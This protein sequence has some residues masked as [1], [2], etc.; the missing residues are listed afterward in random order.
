MTKEKF[1]KYTGPFRG[2]EKWTRGLHILNRI[3]TAMGYVSYPFLLIYLIWTKDVRFFQALLVPG[4][5]FMAVTFFRAKLNAPRPYEVYE[6]APLIPKETRGHSFPS[7]HVFSIFIIAMTFLML[8]PWTWFGIVLLAAGVFLAVVRVLTGV[9]FPRDVIAGALFAVVVALVFYSIDFGA[10][11]HSKSV[12]N[13]EYV[14]EAGKG[15]E[16]STKE[17][18]TI[19]EPATEEVKVEEPVVEEPTVPTAP[20]EPVAVDVPKP[21]E[22]VEVVVSPKAEKL[23]SYK[24]K[25]GFGFGPEFGI[26]NKVEYV[27]IFPRLSITAD[28]QNVFT[29]SKFG[30]GA[31][32]DLTGVFKPLDGTFIGH[33]FKFFLNGNN[34][35]VDAMI[36]AKLMAYANFDKVQLYV[37]GGIGYSIGSHSLYKY[38]HTSDVMIFGFDTAAALSAVVGLDWNINDKLTLTLEGNYRYFFQSS[39]KAQTFAATVGMGF[40]F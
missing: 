34:W 22:V 10:G 4:I 27:T 5:S 31:R 25:L 9:H 8:S 21:A 28:F 13:T 33:E 36:D 11:S 37:D 32:I 26:N 19:E 18:F 39:S 24:F 17:Q 30:F 20:S 23:S 38:T 16:E 3:L 14:T 2:N 29:V 15:T 1:M 40:M 7:R 12:D 6:E 35:A